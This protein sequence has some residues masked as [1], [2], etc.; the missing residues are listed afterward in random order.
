[1][2]LRQLFS[3]FRT[4]L[5]LF[6]GLVLL[7]TSD[8]LVPNLILVQSYYS[9]IHPF[10]CAA[11][12]SPD[13]FLYTPTSVLYV[14]N[15]VRFL[16]YL[17]VLFLLLEVK[18][19]LLPRKRDIQWDGV[20][21][22]VG[23]GLAAAPWLVLLNIEGPCVRLFPLLAAYTVVLWLFIVLNVELYVVEK[24]FVSNRWAVRLME[25]TFPVSDLMF[26]K[27]H[28]QRIG[29]GGGLLRFVPV[30]SYVAIIAV[31]LWMEAGILADSIR[32]D[33]MPVP[34]QDPYFVVYDNGGFWYSDTS[35]GQAG[36]WRYDARSGV[37]HPYIRVQ[38]LHKFHLEDKFFYF[39]DG[40]ENEALKV[41]AETR[42]VVW[43]VPVPHGFGMSELVLR[44]GLIF[45]IGK[46]G[47]IT[48]IDTE[49]HV[50]AE[51]VFPL[52]TWY[53]QVLPDGRI[54]F[55]SPERPYD[56]RIISANLADDEIVPLPLA[57]GIIKF[58]SAD[59]GDRE[60][61][62]VTGTEYAG[63]LQTLYIAT[64]WGEVFRYDMNVRRWLPSYRTAPGIRSIAVDSRN[65]LLFVYNHARGYVDV[66]ELES[67]KHLKYVL[68]NVFGRF[69]NLDPDAMV[70]ILTPRGPG[71]T[72]VPR[73]GGLYHFNYR[74]I[75][76]SRPVRL[77]G[78]LATLQ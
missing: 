42:R 22:L 9:K 30:L 7:V 11:P 72:S 65:G 75:A 63:V 41:D 43:R 33:K 77:T 24:Y 53:P 4:P 14:P 68:A 50:R 12:L 35:S 10:F 26:F 67:G 25:W 76:A 32:A 5:I 58:K 47:Y 15:S 66:I 31:V 70:A 36:I 21:A 8:T 55:V 73:P 6:S 51:R 64:L 1:M 56:V 62:V 3:V 40:Y 46:G 69:I 78:G 49:G 74:S 16:I 44:H 45:V 19:V 61:T 2:Q 28:R 57:N 20:T 54:A 34:V 17:V 18:C 60:I 52:K 23:F 29:P 59:I 37:A 71:A 13:C 38:D 48:V 27:F 39:Y